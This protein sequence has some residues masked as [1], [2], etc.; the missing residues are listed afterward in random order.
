MKIE[1]CYDKDVVTKISTTQQEPEWMLNSRLTAFEQVSQLALPRV[2]KTNIQGWNFTQF[3]PFRPEKVIL[4]L[5]SLSDDITEFLVT[6]TNVIIQKNS[7][8]VYN[9]V[10]EEITKQGIVFTDLATAMRTHEELVKKYYMTGRGKLEHRLT[11]LHTALTSGGIFLYVPRNMEVSVPLQ[12]LFWVK[13]KEAAIFPHILVIAEENS[14]VDFIASFL[15]E[16]GAAINNSIFE[17]FV[18]R[19]ASVRIST[20]N[21]LSK[22]TVDVSYRKSVVE[23]GGNLDWISCDLS[24]GYIISNNTVD[25]RGDGSGLTIKSIALGVEEMRSNNTCEVHHWG[26]HTTSNIHARSVMKDSATNIINSITKIERGAT[27]SDGQQSSKVLM[28]NEKARGDANP[29]LLIDENDVTAGHAAS[30]GRVDPLQIFYMMSR[31]IPRQEA[32]KLIIDGFLDEVI[33]QIPSQSLQKSIHR[34][35]GRKF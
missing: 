17:V 30:V 18:G 5:A 6:D 9:S 12:S 21:N 31:G 32:E 11:A 8:I 2:E 19:D 25:L 26:K 29:I 20:M 3:N 24:E 7:T 10:D 16:E 1:A 33:S 22:S 27:K 23:H 4:D 15:G 35:I 34:L 13:G 28:L 14:R